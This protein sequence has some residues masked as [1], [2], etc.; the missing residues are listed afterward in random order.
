ML[1]MLGMLQRRRFLFP[2]ASVTLP[3]PDSSDEM[4]ERMPAMPGIPGMLGMLPPLRLFFLRIAALPEQKRRK[5]NDRKRRRKRT[6]GEVGTV[7]SHWPVQRTN[8]RG[9][10]SRARHQSEWEINPKTRQRPVGHG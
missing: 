5:Q 10:K 6:D 9:L 8:R 3:P 1:G 2:E 4:L 7:E